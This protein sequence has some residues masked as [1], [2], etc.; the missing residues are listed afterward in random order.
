MCKNLLHCIVSLCLLTLLDFSLTSACTAH[1]NV[2]IIRTTA[3]WQ[4]QNSQVT[5]C[6]QEHDELEDVSQGQQPQRQKD[7][8][9][10]LSKALRTPLGT[11]TLSLHNLLDQAPFLE[12]QQVQLRMHACNLVYVSM[13][14]VQ[15]LQIK[16]SMLM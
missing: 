9:G 6:L 11:R 14:S 3:S 1:K 15:Q 16:M 4:W 2:K 13:F 10:L 8:A 5:A 7:K 12:G